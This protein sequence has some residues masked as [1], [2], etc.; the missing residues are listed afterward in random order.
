MA[1]I[2]EPKVRIEYQGKDITKDLSSTLIAFTYSD[3]EEGE[4]DEL[5]LTLSDKQGLWKG[6]WYPSKGD[7]MRAWVGYDEAMMF[8]GEFVVDSIDFSGPPDTVDLRALAAATSSPLRTKRSTGFESQTLRQIVEQ[9]AARQSL[10]VV[11]EIANIQ[12]AR[13][14][15]N[16]K[17]DLE[18]LRDLA[19]NYGHT[20]SVRGSKL[21]FTKGLDE[22]DAVLTLSPLDLSTYRFSDATIATFKAASVGFASPATGGTFAYTTPDAEGE[23]SSDTLEIRARA[24]NQGHAQTLADSALKKANKN[25]AKGSFTT[26]GKPILVAGVNIVLEG[27]GNIGGRVH[28]TRSV[29]TVTRGGYTTQVEFYRVSKPTAA[30]QTPKPNPKTPTKFIYTG[31]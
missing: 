3:A 8:C 19:N 4:S 2:K 29:H 27:L 24:E 31:T 20:F 5:S 18:F 26:P 25:E 17:S 14:T 7:K 28:I 16:R 21:I 6:P 22:G 13:I 15:Q 12:F 10:E 30:Q 11:G 1:Q 23:T 9:I